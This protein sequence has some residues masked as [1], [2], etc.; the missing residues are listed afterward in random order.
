MFPLFFRTMHKVDKKPDYR[1]IGR[2]ALPCLSLGKIRNKI[3]VWY[4]DQITCYFSFP[5]G[6]S[7][8]RQRGG[9]RLRDGFCLSLI[10][11]VCLWTTHFPSLSSKK[12]SSTRSVF[13]IQA[14]LQEPCGASTTFCG[15][16]NDTRIPRA[17]FL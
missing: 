2:L 13:S 10:I 3:K 11:A 16:D 4:F 9:G 5:V 17:F 8:R 12:R 15:P 6:Q 7:Y 14:T 1:T